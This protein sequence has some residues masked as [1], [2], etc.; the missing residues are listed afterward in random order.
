MTRSKSSAAVAVEPQAR[1]PAK[2]HSQSY[3]QAKVRIRLRQ[4]G[5]AR[6]NLRY[7]EPADD[8]VE[9]L[10]ET[11]LAAGVIIPPIV[12]AGRRGEQEYMAL[13]GRRRRMALLLLLERGAITPDY[14]FDVI[15][16]A[17]K[18]AQAAAVVLPNAEHAP[19]HIASIIA[20]IG[21]FRKAKMDTAFI[22]A[23][24]GYSELEIKRL[25]ALSGVHPKVLAAL[26]AGRITLKQARMFARVEDRAQLAH[27]AQ[28]AL[29]GHFQDYQLRNLI[30]QDQVT[31][32]D[33]RY[34]LVGPA[35]YAG[36]G[37]RLIADLFGEMPD[38][39]LDPDLLDR[40]WRARIAPLFYALEAMDLVVLLGSD[41][42]YGAPDG[43]ETLP[44]VYVPDLDPERQAVRAQARERV[45]AATA[46]LKALDLGEENAIDSVTTLA[47]AQL[48]YARSGLVDRD[49]GA[50]MLTPGGELGVS[51]T[52]YARP[53][54]TRDEPED[55]EQAGRIAAPRRRSVSVA[56]DIAIPEA[57]VEVAG[58]GHSL[59]DA[60]TDLATRGLI[61]D[62]ADQPG[63]ALI[64]LLAQLF[65]HTVLDGVVYQG[66][67]AVSIAATAYK[68]GS[69]PAHPAL[70]GDVHARLD[71]RRQAYKASGLR[72]I[73]FVQALA[74]GEKM[75]L[76]AEMVAVSLDLREVRT[77]LIR[78][79]ARAEAA[80]IARLCDADITAHWT[81]DAA[82]LT[83]HAKP[84]LL[85]M[86][87]A[88]GVEDDRAAGLKKPALVEFVAEA[89]AERRWA[90]SSVTWLSSDPESQPAASEGGGEAPGD[91]A[92]DPSEG[93][94]AG[95]DDDSVG[96]EDTGD[97]GSEPGDPD[98]PDAIAA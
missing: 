94:A 27:L 40:L 65:K 55:D 86:L 29:D 64:A 70:D 54:P 15:L 34:A 11:I 90:P 89:A 48:D 42:G 56:Q 36:S 33:P 2:P 73:G 13:D 46:A 82:F 16:V 28:S 58:I 92:V 4:F 22:A 21:K 30:E 83:V 14:A 78:H 8:G 88:M 80:E 96:D 91:Q 39:L 79:A 85:A 51:T 49:L 31:A 7:D 45:A 52:F 6:E 74:H 38:R 37:G 76:L 41:R 63:V 5:L 24:L 3:S 47:V 25:E 77:G 60:R 81:P 68:R 87:E 61:R 98:D 57:K 59:H 17:D 84:Q 23:S 18:A 9:Q 53:A 43:F 32:D 20:A 72:P 62:L 1:A 95:R 93:P 97:A 69:L 10:A 67:S 75:A 66:E 44:Y 71:A 35:L 12:R 26:R 50:V 19:V